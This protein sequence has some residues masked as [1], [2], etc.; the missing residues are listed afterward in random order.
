[1]E[2]AISRVYWTYDTRLR[3]NRFTVGG[4]VE[5]IV[6]TALR[7][8][9]VPVRH[10]GVIESDIDLQLE[11]GPGGYSLKAIFKG[12]GTRLVNT[13]GARASRERW[14]FATLFLVSGI[15]IVYA[16]PQL[17]WWLKNGRRCIRAAHDAITVTKRC[18]GE[19]ASRHPEWTLPCELPSE[20]DRDQR[21]HPARTHT[22]DLAAQIL[23]EYPLL[24]QELPNLRP[25][26][27]AFD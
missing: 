7:A 5:Y 4:V 21:P 17:E 2:S 11:D 22:A 26:E 8:C 13:M 9:G 25:G 15:G 6:G 10:R 12:A 1:M 24:L 18:V 23:L 20:R 14:A 3:E 16:D 19:F 27:A